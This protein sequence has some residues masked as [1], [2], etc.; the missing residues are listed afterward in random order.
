MLFLKPCESASSIGSSLSGLG[1][2]KDRLRR[3]RVSHAGPSQPI[4]S[5]ARSRLI[6]NPKTD[7]R[8]DRRPDVHESAAQL[9]NLVFDFNFSLAPRRP[10]ILN[11]CPANTTLIPRPV[12]NCVD[13]IALH[14]STW[15][16][17]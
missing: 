3:A 14:T 1:R 7:G 2:F 15:G 8:P 17:S 10:L 6:L 4:R 13:H 16:D 12:P 9:G 5:A 11:P